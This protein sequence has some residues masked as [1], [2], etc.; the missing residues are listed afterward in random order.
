MLLLLRSD[1]RVPTREAFMGLMC[2]ASFKMDNV[3][4]VPVLEA[5][6]ANAI[7]LRLRKMQPERETVLVMGSSKGET[8]EQSLSVLNDVRKGMPFLVIFPTILLA[9]KSEW[10][11]YEQLIG[12]PH[13]MECFKVP[14]PSAE[15]PGTS[16]FVL[17]Q[18]ESYSELTHRL[19]HAHLS[20]QKFVASDGTPRKGE[21]STREFMIGGNPTGTIPRITDKML[22]EAGIEGSIE[23]VSEDRATYPPPPLFIDPSKQ[24]R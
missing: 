18:S 21:E 15:V 19:V 11:H 5:P 6:Q 16:I 3:L 23:P 17:E 24:R 1:Y 7:V 4:E 2:H 22:K 9:R 8:L 10:K 12:T 20:P 13:S 14:D